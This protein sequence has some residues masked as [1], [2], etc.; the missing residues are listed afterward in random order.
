MTVSVTSP[1]SGSAQTG[2]TSP[3]FVLL[4]DTAP[5][6]NGKQVAV[7]SATGTLPGTVT[8][9]SVS[10]PFTHT[11]TKPVNIKVANSAVP[12]TGVIPPAGKNAYKL[13]T[14]KGVLRYSGA[15]PE[16]FTIDSTLSVP[17]GADTYDIA[18]IRAALSAHIGYL[19]Q[20]SAGLGDTLSS[21]VM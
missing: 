20:V 11:F 13:L 3:A 18:N 16:V 10:N 1:L 6:I 19:Q 9:H 7:A 21:G 14:R 8:F 17:V 5:G 2:F 4:T 12:S 15:Q